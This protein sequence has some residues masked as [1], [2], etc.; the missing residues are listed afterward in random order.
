[1]PNTFYRIF[2]TNEDETVS[3]L[4]RK[5]RKCSTIKGRDRQINRVT[6]EMV[7]AIREIRG[8]KRLHVETMTPEQVSCCGLS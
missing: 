8:W 6:N 7:E 3:T 4:Y 1:M 2:I 5:E